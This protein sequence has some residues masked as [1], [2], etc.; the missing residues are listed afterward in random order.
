WL[1]FG[2]TAALGV[3]LCLRA[4]QEAA[5]AGE[6]LADDAGE[7]EGS[8]GRRLGRALRS[9]PVQIA[10]GV[11]VGGG[12]CGQGLRRAEA[13]R[14]AEERGLCRDALTNVEGARPRKK[15]AVTQEQMKACLS[16]ARRCL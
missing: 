9:L 15:R 16:I 1:V 8:L 7:G 3:A 14:A 11:L 2:S 13:A 10:L 4:R 5:D 6:D 12:L